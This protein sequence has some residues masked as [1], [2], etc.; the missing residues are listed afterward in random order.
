MYNLA[1]KICF[2]CREFLALKRIYL[3]FFQ[4]NQMIIYIRISEIL[5][6][7]FKTGFS[8]HKIHLYIYGQEE[9]TKCKLC[10]RKIV[11]K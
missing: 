3:L 7:A 8:V 2:M 10:S 4:I 11:A 9:N 1:S 5:K 6:L